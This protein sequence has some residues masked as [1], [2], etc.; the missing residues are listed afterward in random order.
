MSVRTLWHY[1]CSDHG[2]PGI[3]SDGFLRLSK[4]WGQPW[5]PSAV[6]LTDLPFP[7]RERLGLTSV[8]LD[9]DRTEVRFEVETDT[10][11]RWKHFAAEHGIPRQWR[12][13][14]ESQGADPYRWFLSTEPVRVLIDAS[15]PR[16]EGRG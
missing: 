4:L 12:R 13:M 10:A 8:L 1:T 9:C 6:W 3:R 16:V 14:L 2:A 7:D 5:A 11:V 15:C